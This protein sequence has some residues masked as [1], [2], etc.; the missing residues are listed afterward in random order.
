M[1]SLRATLSDIGDN[2][3]RSALRRMI[4]RVETRSSNARKDEVEV[5]LPRDVENAE[6]VVSTFEDDS[7]SSDID[8]KLIEETNSETMID[9]DTSPEPSIKRKGRLYLA[10]VG[11]ANGMVL[12]NIYSRDMTC[13][14]VDADRN[15]VDFEGKTMS[16]SRAAQVAYARL[17]RNRISGAFRGS[18][19]W[20]LNGVRI[21][22]LRPG[23]ISDDADQ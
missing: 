6:T 18:R 3:L 15:F 17:G 5:F 23:E 2:D 12:E 16:L 9:S 11:I 19:Y 22:D 8:H 7:L 1:G 4:I 14:V 10:D 21:V 20:C 13:R